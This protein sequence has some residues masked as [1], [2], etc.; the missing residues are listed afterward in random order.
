MKTAMIPVYGNIALYVYKILRCL[1]KD[2]LYTKMPSIYLFSIFTMG[3][4]SWRH[5][6]MYS[7]MYTDMIGQDVLIAHINTPL[8]STNIHK[9]Y[10]QVLYFS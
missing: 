1:S 4:L 6:E 3:S 5:W 10:L 9:A 7:D 2:R 8:L